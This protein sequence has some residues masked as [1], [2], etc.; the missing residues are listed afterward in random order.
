MCIWWPKKKSKLSSH[1]AACLGKAELRSFSIVFV[2][3]HGF[4]PDLNFYELWQSKLV[5]EEIEKSNNIESSKRRKGWALH[6]SAWADAKLSWAFGWYRSER[7][8]LRHF[9]IHNYSIIA[10]FKTTMLEL[11]LKL[12]TMLAL[13]SHKHTCIDMMCIV[14]I[15]C[16]T[17]PTGNAAFNS[18]VPCPKIP[19]E[20]CNVDECNLFIV[21]W[22][23]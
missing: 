5:F 10:H 12:G 19:T 7:K 23:S 1:G 21:T 4:R 14:D 13:L 9:Q 6:W 15:W 11:H 18:K 16:Y 2:P 22:K 20:H 17:S 8:M 3:F